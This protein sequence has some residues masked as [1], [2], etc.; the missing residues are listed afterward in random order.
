[1]PMTVEIRGTNL[2]VHLSAP[3]RMPREPRLDARSA[4][5]LGPSAGRP[6]RLMRRVAE[7]A[8][9]GIE[10]RAL[11]RDDPDG[12]DFIRRLAAVGGRAGPSPRSWHITSGSPNSRAGIPPPCFAADETAPSS[13]THVQLDTDADGVTLWPPLRLPFHC[14]R[15]DVVMVC[16]QSHRSPDRRRSSALA[17]PYDPSG[18]LELPGVAVL[19]RPRPV[20]AFLLRHPFTTH[21]GDASAQHAA[22]S[23][24]TCWGHSEHTDNRATAPIPCS[25]GNSACCY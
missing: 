16:S 8:S 23:S 14:P 10:H 4:F 25:G 12:A 3:P 22:S 2:R 18:R 13:R 5:R 11:I 1:M 9:G 20:R 24:P 15:E 19:S 7:S 6:P 21:P 17:G